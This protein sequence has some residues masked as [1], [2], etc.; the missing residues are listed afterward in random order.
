MVRRAGGPIER[1][2][3]STVPFGGAMAASGGY[4]NRPGF[5]ALHDRG[6]VG[7]GSCR[8]MQ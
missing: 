2:T 8:G 7:S 5:G 6:A 4:Q 3:G 1:T